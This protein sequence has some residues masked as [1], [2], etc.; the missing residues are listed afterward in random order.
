MIETHRFLTRARTIDHLG[1]E[2]IADCPTAISELW[3]NSYDAYATVAALHIFD[4]EPN[5]ATIFDNGHGMSQQEFIDKWLVVGTESKASF[6]ITPIADRNGLAY[7]RRQ[8]QKGIGRLSAAYLANFFL[9]VTKRR[10]HPF[11]AALIDWR[12]FENPFLILEDVEIPVS[13]FPKQDQLFEILPN[14][15]DTLMGNLWGNANNEK[16]T[17]RIKNAWN[18]Y[19]Q[20]RLKQDIQSDLNHLPPSRQIEN[21]L[22]TNIF[23]E[24]HIEPWPAWSGDAE[25]GTIMLMSGIIPDL[26]AQLNPSTKSPFEIKAQETFASTLWSFIDP[27]TKPSERPSEQ[28]NAF[29]TSVIGWKDERRLSIIERFAGFESEATALLEHVIDGA[30]DEDGVFRGK[31]KAFGNWLTD[32][33]IIPPVE[34]QSTRADSRVGPFAF[35]VGSMEFQRANTTLTDECHRDLIKA[36]ER[37]SGLMVFRNGF[38]VMPYGRIDSDFFGVEERRS[39]SFG[40]EFWNHRQM[41]GRVAITYEDNPNLKDKAGREGIIDN[42]AAKAFRLLVVNI[43]MTTARLYFGSSSKLRKEILPPL[44]DAYAKKKAEEERA[45]LLE[46]KRREFRGALKKNSPDATALAEDARQLRQTLIESSQ[47]AIAD[48]T[49]FRN[50]FAELS[51]RRIALRL[52]PPPTRLAAKQKELH[53]EYKA[54]LNEA[55][56]IIGEAEQM[57]SRELERLTLTKPE[58]HAGKEIDIQARQVKRHL[59]KLC[60]EIRN[61]LDQEKNKLQEYEKSRIGILN[62]SLAPILLDV[63][64]ANLSLHEGIKLISSTAERIDRENETHLLPVRDALQ[65]LADHINLDLIATSTSEETDDL[66]AEIDRLN[67]LAQLGITVEIIDHELAAL[68]STI[69]HGLSEF[70]ENI[71]SSTPFRQVKSAFESLISRLQFLSP[72]KLSGSPNYSNIKGSDIYSFLAEFFKTDISNGSLTLEA[73]KEFLNFSVYEQ[74]ARILPVFVNLVN[75]S[76]YWIHQLQNPDPKVVLSVREGKIIVSDNGPGIPEQDHSDLFKIF[77][78]KRHGGRGVGLYLCRSNLTSGGHKISY[79]ETSECRVLQGANFAI[80]FRD[81]IFE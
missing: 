77:F 51:Q 52:G 67:A 58:E 54:N 60:E 49:R 22:I 9:L 32:E 62:E 37:F 55:Y 42:Q 12:I 73:S 26:S 15:Y 28:V 38:R 47:L 78:T 66:R 70:P 56:E 63:E 79:A 3:K 40:R 23:S 75:N 81:A 19:D 4:T 5:V 43:L 31:V 1:R 16:R 24:R 34:R 18:S 76:R 41:L 80:E 45:R 6:S 13:S 21:T 53:A 11:T 64:K 25:S 68:T 39:K 36:F 10:D 14:L 17:E 61:L 35:Y 7:R 8:G 20:L 30:V 57:I 50:S 46:R 59:W 74:P 48:L 72:L 44:K 71:I 33:V 65:L 69:S 27:F 29:E 2:Q